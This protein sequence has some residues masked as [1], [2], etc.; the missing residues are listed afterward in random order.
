MNDHETLE[1]LIQ[2]LRMHLCKFPT[3]RF[4]APHQF[5]EWFEGLEQIINAHDELTAHKTTAG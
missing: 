3:H 1:N 4:V 5:A 2:T